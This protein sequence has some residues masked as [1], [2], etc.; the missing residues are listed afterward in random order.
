MAR[1]YGTD[2]P[3]G[4]YLSGLAREAG[5]AT[6]ILGIPLVLGSNASDT[7][8]AF[9]VAANLAGLGA[10]AANPSTI[11]GGLLARVAPG[12]S[13]ALRTPILGTNIPAVGAAAGLANLGT[14]IAATLEAPTD[15]QKA[16]MAGKTAFD[17]YQAA[18][19]MG[20]APQIPGAVTG[21]A[22]IPAAAAGIMGGIV[23][24]DPYIQKTLQE[25]YGDTLTQIMNVTAA[26]GAP[27]TF[28]GSTF[29]PAVT[30]GLTKAFE[31]IFGEKSKY[32]EKRQRVGDFLSSYGKYIPDMILG[33]RTPDELNQALDVIEGV[34]KID[35]HRPPP[36]EWGQN[37]DAFTAYWSKAPDEVNQ[38]LTEL[39]R[40]A[41]KFNQLA[42]AV[43]PEARKA[44]MT[45][46]QFLR[47]AGRDDLAQFA[48]RM[49]AARSSPAFLAVKFIHDNAPRAGEIVDLYN[50]DPSRFLEL[51]KELTRHLPAEAARLASEWSMGYRYHLPQHKVSALFSAIES[52]IADRAAK[53]A[54]QRVAELNGKWVDFG[55]GDWAWRGTPEELEE[56][57][58]LTGVLGPGPVPVNVRLIM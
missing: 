16:V 29:A 10:Y 4:Q 18:A 48:E 50:R 46:P 33:A 3:G 54:A 22:A 45:V 58:Q 12:V 56:L 30:A 43:E 53:A 52:E 35:F 37:P 57:R 51:A 38:S 9:G 42:R 21:A 32:A 1:L 19:S 6:N 25:N 7:R 17:A 8:K 28:G 31:S 47:A 2:L 14:G 15:A 41:L 55:G 26:L 44:G 27:F 49:Q 39:V 13:S 40:F 11:G 20:A 24:S 5:A 34:S 36:S 23:S